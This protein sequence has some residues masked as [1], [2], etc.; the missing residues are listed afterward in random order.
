[1][2]KESINL[3]LVEDDA[4]DRKM[5]KL[6]LNRSSNVA[7]FN[8]EAAETLSQATECL[9]NKDYDVVLLDLG[10]P[11]SGGVNTV[12]K[13]HEAN[14]NV[15]IIVLT[16]LSEGL[17]LEAIAKG[18][19]DYLVKGK[20]LEHALFRIIRY[21]IERKKVE[22]KL[23]EAIEAKSQFMSMVSH[24][25]RVPLTSIKESIAIVLDGLAGKISEEQ[26]NCLDIA[27]RNIDRL[28]RLVS[29]LLDFNK[30]EAGKMNFDMQDGNVNETAK[31][32]YDTMLP[33]A[34]EKGMNLVLELDD[35]LARVK[36]DRDKINQVMSNLVNN[37]IK[38]TKQGRITIATSKREGAIQVSVS[39]TGCGI[40]KEDLP[41]LFHEFE[42]LE[43]V[44]IEKTRG[45]GLGL[46]ISKEIIARHNGEIRAESELGK[47]S[48]FL[49]TLPSLE[50][51]NKKDAELEACIAS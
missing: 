17:G 23:K 7:D 6:A 20:S 40:K 26:R 15:P 13:A 46:A 10:L 5:V 32:V 22:K 36:F 18:A 45:T 41:R 8:V 21:A 27:K 30:L 19:E 34:K 51:N 48:T 24:E 50:L 37:A 1:M 44:G 43:A 38:F 25:L 9:K 12:Q 31:D 28:N 29:D 3:L 47:G 49:F 4:G 16:G 2:H 35:C 42:Q 39:D 33:V 11:D 14:P